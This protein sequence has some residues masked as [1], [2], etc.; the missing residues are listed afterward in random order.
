M[1]DGEPGDLGE[2]A[3]VPV[4][5]VCNTLLGTVTIPNPKMEGNTV[6][7]RGFSTAPVTP[8]PALIAMVRDGL[9]TVPATNA[10]ICKLLYTQLYLFAQV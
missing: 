1:A 5:E 3:H 7:A 4:E 8:R 9:V 2:I 10:T 6:R